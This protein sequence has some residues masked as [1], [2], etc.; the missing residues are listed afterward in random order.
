MSV[1]VWTYIIVG[2]S[3]ILRTNILEKKKSNIRRTNILHSLST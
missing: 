3:F 2:L 1:Q